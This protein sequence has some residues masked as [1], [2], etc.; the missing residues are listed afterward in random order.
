MCVCECLVWLLSVQCHP[1]PFPIPLPYSPLSAAYRHGDVVDKDL[2]H[3]Q[4]LFSGSLHHTGPFSPTRAAVSTE[5]HE[6][7]SK[8]APQSEPRERRRSWFG[9]YPHS[10][11]SE[12]DPETVD[13]ATIVTRRPARR[14]P[15]SAHK[16]ITAKVDSRRSLPVARV[17]GGARGPAPRKAHPP[18]VPLQGAVR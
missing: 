9:T 13:P 7:P 6:A 15:N 10:E 16:H 2:Q 14:M 17:H 3:V 1:C 5:L 12:S 18:P 11:G 4:E 8:D